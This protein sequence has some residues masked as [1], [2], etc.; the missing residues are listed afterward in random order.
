MLHITL[1]KTRS[2]CSS[3][4]Y[5]LQKKVEEGKKTSWGMDAENAL[6]YIQAVFIEEGL[7][8]GGEL[9]DLAR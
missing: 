8:E 3:L 7:G 5:M 6:I 9:S 1:S 2:C 4:Q